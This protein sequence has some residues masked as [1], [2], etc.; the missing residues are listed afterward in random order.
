[1]HEL[2]LSTLRA[3]DVRTISLDGEPW[4]AAI[5]VL[6]ALGVPRRTLSHHLVTLQDDER[7]HVARPRDVPSDVKFGNS[8]VEFLSLSG[9]FKLLLRIDAP[10]AE[11]FQDW[12]CREL[13][14]DL[15]MG[16]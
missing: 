15:W 1:M 2:I 8:G 13:L 5:D 7:R 14:S 9:L 11:A 10:S 16:R 12:V 4:F 3:R 6:A